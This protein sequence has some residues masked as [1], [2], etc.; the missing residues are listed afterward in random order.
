MTKQYFGSLAMWFAFCVLLAVIFASGT[1]IYW[2]LIDIDPPT[3][4]KSVETFDNTGQKRTVF[5]PGETMVIRRESCVNDTGEAVFT[6]MLIRSDK[7]EIYFL[8]SGPQHLAIGCRT[9]W[10]SVQVPTF[11]GPGL[12]D[13]VVKISFVN[14]P[15][16]TSEQMMLIPRIEIA[17]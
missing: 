12:Y 13:Y 4:Q 17:P 1:V 10:N 9:S 2:T 11:I 3:V 5:H 14:N 7:G 8:S 16:M 15:L 6:R